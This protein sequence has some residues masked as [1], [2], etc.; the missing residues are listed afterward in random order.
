MISLSGKRWSAG[1]LALALGGGVAA[2]PAALAA[3]GQRPRFLPDAYARHALARQEADNYWNQ[4]AAGYN[5]GDDMQPLRPPSPLIFVFLAAP[6]GAAMP[7]AL[8]AESATHRVERTM[9]DGMPT[10]FRIEPSVSGLEY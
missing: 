8:C 4:K 1:L 5:V 9:E 3:G 10:V 6:G 2:F 7:E